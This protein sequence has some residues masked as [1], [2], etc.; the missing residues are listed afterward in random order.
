LA[1]GSVPSREYQTNGFFFAAVAVPPG[2]GV[3]KGIA[4]PPRGFLVKAI[5]LAD[6]FS[7]PLPNTEMDPLAVPPPVFR[8][9]FIHDLPLVPSEEQGCTYI[10]VN[11]G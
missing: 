8:F 9:S 7:R 1:V 5:M 6:G 10:S 4:F 3:E 11:A 2:I